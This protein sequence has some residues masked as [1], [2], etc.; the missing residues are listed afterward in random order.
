LRAIPFFWPYR[1]KI[2]ISMVFAV[3]V[4]ILWGANLSVAYPVLQ[5]LLKD[6]SIAEYIDEQIAIVNKEIENKT[7]NIERNTERIAESQEGP[8]GEQHVERLHDQARQQSHLS[9]A[10]SK[11]WWL[12]WLKTT[13]LPWLPED[14]FDVLALLLLALLTATMLKGILSF[15]QQV[16]IGSVVELTVM[17]IR[18]E[19]FRRTLALDYQTISLCGTP[20]L[21]S[22]F[23]HDITVMAHGLTLMGGKVI[24][25]PLKAIACLSLAFY[26]NW[27]LTLLSLLMAPV[28]ALAFYRIGN[29]LKHA[30]RRL[31]ESMS[32]IYKTLEETLDGFKV[33]VAFNGG[34]QHRRRFHQES[35]R[36]Y[37]KALKIVKLDAVTSPTIETLGM[38]VAFVALLP[39][40]YLVLRNTTSIWGIRL[41]AGPMQ[42]EDLVLIYVFLAGAIDPARKLSTTYSKVK[43]AAAAAD[44]VF[45]LVDRQPLVKQT[46]HPKPLARH[47]KSIVFRNIDFTYAST[48]TEVISRPAALVD[49]SLEV[50]A[51]EVVAV[52]GENGSGK[53]TLV[54][55]LPRYFDPQRGQV[56]ID[57]VDIRD[58]RLKDLRRQIGVVTQ[59]TLLFDDTIYENIRY[60][61]A[62]ATPLDVE[63]AAHQAN[64]TQ[65]VEGL[66]DRF[67]TSVG[68][69]GGR[70]SGGQRQR[71]ALARAIL[72]DPAILILDEATSAIDA[73]SEILI[74]EALCRFVRGRTVFLITH[75]VRPSLLEFVTRIVVMERGR[76][77]AAGRHD[78]LIQSCPTYQRLF[79]AR[80]SAAA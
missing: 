30:S 52:V 63:R 77:L 57:D 36:Y 71:I 41:A 80:G 56:L 17:G 15:A 13:V 12:T 19:C 53:S 27:R 44:R 11:L 43:R 2:A 22:R 74:H 4:A 65:F 1:R 18:K 45:A 70:L 50:Q 34:Q 26:V 10:L 49:V 76:L 29:L 46:A 64:V 31:M 54:N 16:L 39:G 61:K 60:G 7:A 35:K 24:Q 42:I 68:E 25:E 23:T 69:K 75:S 9:A 5:V 51:G 33:V 21:M 8:E 48:E 40:A 78:E 47:S 38:I 59:E 55:L 58:V 72:R 37:A 20:D 14:K 73:Q 67:Q 28:I 62:D 6:R 66:P 79:Q 32:R 3:L